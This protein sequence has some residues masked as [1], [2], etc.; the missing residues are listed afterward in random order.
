MIRLSSLP[1]HVYISSRDKVL[2][3]DSVFKI[4]DY[5]SHTFLRYLLLRL[6]K[7]TLYFISKLRYLEV[8]HGVNDPSTPRIS[9]SVHN[10]CQD[11]QPELKTRNE[12]YI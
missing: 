8:L 6:E 9:A 11:G 4:I 5:I 1:F 2:V 3:K 12:K 7:Y 10:V